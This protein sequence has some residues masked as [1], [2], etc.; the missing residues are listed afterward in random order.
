[1]CDAF[2]DRC[3]CASPGRAPVQTFAGTEL[4][5][6]ITHGNQTERALTG[7]FVTASDCGYSGC[8]ATAAGELPT[9]TVAITLLVKGS[10]TETSFDPVFAI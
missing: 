7:P 4:A 9:G 8:V 6:P 2:R 10:S 1:M 3:V 5:V